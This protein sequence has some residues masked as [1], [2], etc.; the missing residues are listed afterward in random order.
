[1]TR[2]AFFC[3]NKYVRKRHT[4][5]AEG[6]AAFLINLFGRVAEWSKATVCKTVGL[7]PT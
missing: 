7:R 6:F 2:P 1:M 3:Y 4:L 5:A